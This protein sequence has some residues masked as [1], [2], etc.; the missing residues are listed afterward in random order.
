MRS[1][2]GSS[3]IAEATFARHRPHYSMANDGV[4]PLYQVYGMS[5]QDVVTFHGSNNAFG[6][7]SYLTRH[8]SIGNV[9]SLNYN[10]RE[11]FF[12]TV[13]D[14]LKDMISRNICRQVSIEEFPYH[15]FISLTTLYQEVLTTNRYWFDYGIDKLA[16]LLC[17]FLPLIRCHRIKDEPRCIAWRKYVDENR[18]FA[19]AVLFEIEWNNSAGSS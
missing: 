19:Q 6:S 5:P 3:G 14:V 17:R 1:H 18:M 11:R 9:M 2:C 4:Q 16:H 7:L 10:R 12:I 15:K 13:R 8:G